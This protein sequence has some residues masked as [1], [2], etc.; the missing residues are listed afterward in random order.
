[1]KILAFSDLHRDLDQGAQLVEMSAQAD[2]VIG[3]G[4]FASMHEGL[5]ETIG[6]LSGIETPTVLVPGNN[7]TAEALREA[8][9][10]WDAATVLHGEATTIDCT[11]FFG[12][13][14]G[15]PVTPWDWSFDLDDEAATEML[16]SCPEGAVLVLHSPPKDHCDSA[17]PG[18]GNFGSPALLD[19]IETKRPRLAV[20][21]HI[22]ESWGCE[23]E[24]GPTPVRNLGP[25]GTWIKV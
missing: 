10:G 1:M 7:E 9:A 20:C 6:A 16:S 17:G 11:E 21:G 5:E 19:A 15:I 22:H 2:V 24:I 25:K 14:A 4:D 3:A 23:S 13:G 8:T 12:L 18:G